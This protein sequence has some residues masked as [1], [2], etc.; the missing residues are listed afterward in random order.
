MFTARLV[1]KYLSVLNSIYVRIE[2]IR[3][4]RQI[5]LSKGRARIFLFSNPIHSNLGDQ[6]QTFCIL[7]WFRKYYPDY[8]TICFSQEVTTDRVLQLVRA[9]LNTKDRLFIHSGY[10]FFDPH[11]HLP[12]ICKI[13]EFFKDTKIVILP[14]TVNLK[15][16]SII[17][18]VQQAFDNHS[19][20]YLF[21]RDEISFK[22]GKA[23]FPKC[24]LYLW[25][26]FV[27]SLI[28][29]IVFDNTREGVLFC[30]R[31][32]REKYY[33]DNEID[34]LTSRFDGI[35]SF[36]FDTTIHL[37]PFAWKR[38]RAKY[39]FKVLK[40]FSNFQLVITDRYHGTIF[41]QIA[42]TPVIVLSSSD[43]KLASGVKW[44]S[45]ESFKNSVYFA[46][47]LEVAY[48]LGIEI[49]GRRE[50]EKPASNY[51]ADNYFG[52]LKGV[53]ESE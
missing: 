40:M 48:E 45:D 20:L 29:N 2:R 3:L 27:T 4:L 12:F 16:D 36:R 49:L 30:I 19:N 5:G 28:G 1:G 9:D 26:D 18:K 7:E 46:D 33:S 39:I 53:I 32:D 10:L 24:K 23:L 6:A 37:S 44:F 42:S 38:N 50:L 47:N 13:I 41:S 51:F 15:D 8:H 11:P 14:Q 25:P 22:N 31:N 34:S 52:K 21:C 43:H 17:Q 35:P